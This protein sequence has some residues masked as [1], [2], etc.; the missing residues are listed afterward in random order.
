MSTAE[1][2][3]SATAAA[4]PELDGGEGADATDAELG[5]DC[6]KGCDAAE[7]SAAGAVGSSS[8]GSTS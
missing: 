7:L 1:T 4:G 6:D 2:G 3:A 8:T 5:A